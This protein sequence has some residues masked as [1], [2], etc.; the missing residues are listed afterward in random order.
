M[1]SDFTPNPDV[2]QM[3]CIGVIPTNPDISGVGV[4]AAIYI[5]NFLSFLPALWALRDG[6]ISSDEL[7]AV[8]RQS[9]TI[10][11]TAFAILISTLIQLKTYGLS[12]FHTSIILNL[13]WI[14]NTNAF[15]YFILY[16]QYKCDG[17]RGGHGRIQPSWTAWIK[18]GRHVLLSKRT[19]SL[20]GETGHLVA[21]G[22]LTCW[23]SE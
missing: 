2:I 18:H 5:Q 7:E 17:S 10:L 20:D 23:I 6:K 19:Y 11:I 1:N 16:I 4:R 3:D 12:A 14:N 22:E 21:D 8:E 9:T 13:S 15:I